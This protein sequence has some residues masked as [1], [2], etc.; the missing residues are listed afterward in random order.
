MEYKLPYEWIE[1]RVKPERQ[2][3][4]DHGNFTLRS[5]LPERWWQYGEKRPALYHAIGRS[6]HFEKHPKGWKP[7]KNQMERVLVCS[8][9]T[10]YLSFA[11]VPVDWIFSHALAVF[12]KASSDVFAF[13]SSFVNDIWARKNASHLENR[14]RYT[15]SDVFETLPLPGLS[16]S[17]LAALGEKSNSL[18]GKI[19]VDE[20]IGL[21]SVYNRLHRPDDK[22]ARI[23]ALRELSRDIDLAVA[24]AYGWD[25]LDIGHGFHD[26]PYL[27]ENDRVRFTISEPARI[28]VLRRLSELNR[29]RYNEEVEKGAN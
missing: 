7:T 28:E 23:E 14:L 3:R 8:K 21:T 16:D 15:P 19:C 2:R 18:R 1:E 22:D 10:K 25:D 20:N 24:A 26:V 12:A 9:V 29:Q 5:P 4:N 11:F 17:A 6:Y 27:P 13:L